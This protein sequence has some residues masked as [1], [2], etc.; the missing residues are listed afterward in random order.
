ME[1]KQGDSNSHNNQ[2]NSIVT[3][4]IVKFYFIDVDLEF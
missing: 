3:A 4:S 1:K 2:R